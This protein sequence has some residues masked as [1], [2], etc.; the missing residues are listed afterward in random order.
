MLVDTDARR[1][2]RLQQIEQ[3][4]ARE[5]LSRSRERGRSAGY[6]CVT[7]AQLVRDGR[8]MKPREYKSGK[9]TWRAWEPSDA[10][11]RLLM[12]RTP[13]DT[14]LVRERILSFCAEADTDRILRRQAESMGI[15]PDQWREWLDYAC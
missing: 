1:A 12:C 4:K 9:Q 14:V 15:D 6:A 10:L 5:P 8:A 7:V 3:Q 11:L 2:S 13:M